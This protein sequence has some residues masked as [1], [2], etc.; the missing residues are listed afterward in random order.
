[1]KKILHNKLYMTSFVSDMISNFGDV[2]FYLVLMNYV[3]LLPNPKYA[4]AI[5]S[6][7]ETIP[8]LTTFISGYFADKTKNKVDKIIYTLCL[9]AVLYLTIG[10]LLGFNPSLF[11]LILISI[12]NFVSDISGQYESSL[13]IPISVKI[14][15]DEDRESASAFRQTASNILNIVFRTISAILVGIFTYQQ[16][17]YINAGTFII[18]MII[19]LT[20]RKKLKNLISDNVVSPIN[21]KRNIYADFINNF[22]KTFD[23]LKKFPDL[24]SVFLI[25]P[26]INGV[27]T[28]INPMILLMISEYKNFV[29]VNP[30]ITISTISILL[31]VFSIMGGMLSTNIFKKFSLLS[32][33]F[34]GLISAVGVFLSFYFRNIY[35]LSI[36]L[37]IEV[38]FVTALQPKLNARTINSLP[39]DNLASILGILN[40]YAQIGMIFI[41][42]IFSWVI[43]FLNTNI[44][45]IIF[46]VW[47]IMLLIFIKLK[48]SELN[49]K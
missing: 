5:V 26:F 19:I 28:V 4:I 40:T 37:S 48:R 39:K 44:I 45:S 35:L 43:T 6:I 33:L 18:S 22:K 13:F 12:L 25:A 7:S 47:L 1:M 32:L 27:F 46:I 21:E 41:S 24:F 30:Q 8:T 14:I 49:D 29:F 20:I 36:F 16:L 2:L 9:R 11:I 42:L 3:L 15:N 38:V 31:T 34:Y 23:E 10:V 17:A